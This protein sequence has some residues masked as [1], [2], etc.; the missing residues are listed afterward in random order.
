MEKY[1]NEFEKYLRETTTDF[2]KRSAA[3][4]LNE[5]SCEDYIRKVA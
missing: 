4:W 1:D 2:Y 3:K 5:M